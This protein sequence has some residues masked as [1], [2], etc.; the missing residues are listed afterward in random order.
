MLFSLKKLPQSTVRQS[1]FW[2]VGAAVTTGA[3][4]AGGGNPS[5]LAQTAQNPEIRVGVVQRFGE[6]EDDELIVEP[7]EGL[8]TL[9]F[10][11]GAQTQ[12]V[13]APQAKLDIALQPLPK[14]A[15]QERVVLSSHRSFE[16]AED[17]ANQWRDR[18]I[19]VE[20]A[21]PSSWQVWAKREVY[22]TP[23]L[24]R[25]LLK[26]VQSRGFDQVF[27]DS[28]VVTAIP[29]AA[30]IANGY[31]YNRDRF[32]ITTPNRRIR[33]VA[34]EGPRDR[35]L[36]GGDLMLQ[37]NAYG[38]YTLV[39]EVP[40]ETYLRGV[41]PYEIGLGAPPSTIEAQAIL[42]RTYALRNLRRFAIDD[43]QLC[44][45]TQCQVYFGIS[46]AAEASDRAIA[47]TQGLVLTYEN[48]LIDALYSS[49]TGGVTA[50]FSDVWNGADRPYLQSVIDSV[51]PVW[52]L[53]QKPLSAEANI[54][55]FLA[56]DQGFNE[57]DWDLFRWQAESDLTEIA[58]DLKTYLQRQQH[59]LANLTQVSQLQVTERSTGGRIQKLAIQTDVGVVELAKDEIIRALAAP[60]SLLFYIDPVYAAPAE[61]AAST[62]APVLK[63]YKFVGGG[64][65]HGVGMSQ[66]GAYRLGE[67]GWSAARIVQFYYPNTE[68]KP[69]SRELTF[70]RQPSASPGSPDL[71]ASE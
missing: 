61:N 5:A 6:A 24:R 63:G 31:R 30:F 65:G 15:L 4:A 46:G 40:I 52:N 29:K 2:L 35:S 41:V 36:Y 45:D 37:P 60:R 20:I 62:P 58:Q 53:S 54:R 14:P 71:P 11:T 19:E 26:N 33:V 25:L 28:E 68:L 34:G 10:K 1:L 49:T 66:T 21:Q 23:L 22:S 50:K 44:A 7:L 56:L 57:D 55:A 12:T 27:L 13:S 59:P 47:A 8:L 18:G 38:T 51:Q 39:N 43:Y 16:S 70:W 17:S 42:A 64:W 3:I 67:L 48:E 32:E 69:I 9:T